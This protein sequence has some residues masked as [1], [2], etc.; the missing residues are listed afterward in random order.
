M[1]VRRVFGP[2]LKATSSLTYAFWASLP[3]LVLYEVL[4][5]LT[6][7]DPQTTVRLAA[8]LWLQAIPRFFG[9]GTLVFTIMVAVAWGVYATVSDRRN[10]VAL[11]GRF[12]TGMVLES[13]AWSVALALLVSK[14]TQ[15]LFAMAAE[16]VGGLSTGQQLALSLGA[17]L[18]EELVFRV[19]LVPVLVYLARAAGMGT[20]AAAVAGIV[21]GALLFSAVH[22]MGSLGDPFTFSSFTY[23]FLFGMVLNALLLIRGF[24]ITAWT[25]SLYNVW[26]ILLG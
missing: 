26:V 1:P 22:Y 24:G 6:N 9:V 5:R 20:R 25:H 4:I 2:Y 11:R 7:P 10:P 8:D 19:M 18:Y 14:A 17:G 21:V 23:R 15:L 13:F 16:G 12:F 3:L